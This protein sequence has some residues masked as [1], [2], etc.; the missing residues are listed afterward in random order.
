MLSSWSQ[1]A[2]SSQGRKALD[3]PDPGFTTS[4][5]ETSTSHQTAEASVTSSYYSTTTSIK[6]SAVAESAAPTQ[7]LDMPAKQG[8]NHHK[9]ILSHEAAVTLI[10][11]GVLGKSSPS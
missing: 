2:S 5:D 1:T 8:G 10:V 9:S 7:T 6:A 4:T 3:P 11:L